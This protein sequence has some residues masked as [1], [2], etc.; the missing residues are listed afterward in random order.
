[1]K[2]QYLSE[3]VAIKTVSE[4]EK[5][6]V[7][8]IEGLYSGYGITMG[9]ALRRVLYSSLPGAAVT[10]IKIKGIGH[11]FTAMENVLEDAVTISLNFKKLR[12]KMY[13]DEPQALTV[14]VKGEKKIYASDIK[15][16]AQIELVTPE[17]L[18]ATL[19]AKNAEFEAELTVEKGLGYVPSEARKSEKLPIGAIALDAAFSPVI[20]VNFEVE[21]MRIGDRTDYN[22]VRF[23]IVTD[24]T[25]APSSALHKASNILK[26]HFEK[27]SAVEV[28]KAAEFADVKVMADKPE[29]KAKSKKTAKKK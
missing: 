27:V 7:F 17:V 19:T 22:R 11:E 26:D 20:K 25:I 2:Y 16:N 6:G 29:K 18:L 5:E 1:M 23:H 10:Q 21:N 8:E 9:N 28:M 24:G 3:T 14:K 15:T 12:F 13:T 4:N